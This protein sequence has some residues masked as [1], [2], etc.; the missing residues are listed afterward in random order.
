[1]IDR[2]A[3]VAGAAVAL[4]AADAL[5]QDDK[6][7]LRDTLLALEI[8]S[9]QFVKDKNAAGMNGFMADDGVL[10]FYDG[11]RFTKAQFMKFE[12][13]VAS[14]T[15]D[16]ASA[17]VLVASPDVAIL[18]YRVTYASAMKG[19]KPVTA[20]VSAADTYVRR[21]GKWQ[22]LYYQETQVK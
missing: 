22:S 17:Q 7:K 3:L 12:F 18:L 5:A 9:W 6:A 15:V 14:F 1:M 19:G 21:G 2:R 16:R 10:M 20:T 11:S 4:M 13:D 8:G